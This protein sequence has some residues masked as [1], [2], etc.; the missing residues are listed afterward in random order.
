MI[1]RDKVADVDQT[2]DMVKFKV[3]WWFK[4]HGV[5][6]KETLTAILL[7]IKDLCVD[8]SRSKKQRIADWIPPLGCGLKFNVDGSALRWGKLVWLV[9]E[10]S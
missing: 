2:I 10:V 4:H 8:H 6:S 9:L 7:N 5:S 1:S 3:G